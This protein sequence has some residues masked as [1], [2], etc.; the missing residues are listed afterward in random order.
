[1]REFIN[2]YNSTEMNFKQYTQSTSYMGLIYGMFQKL[3]ENLRETESFYIYIYIYK[4]F[5]NCL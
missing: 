2:N 3:S 5:L 1:M 4:L